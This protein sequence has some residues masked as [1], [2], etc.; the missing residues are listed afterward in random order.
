MKYLLLL[1]AFWINTAAAVCLKYA[2]QEV[3]LSG[4]VFLKTFFGPPNFGENPKT[5]SKLP[6]ALLQLDQPLC[7][8]ATADGFNE[9]ERDQKVITLVPSNKMRLSQFKGKQVTVR[10][11]LFHAMTGYH[12]TPVLIEVNEIL[13]NNP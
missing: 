4:K 1:T 5:D 6:Q 7:T 9:A 8:V 11:T 10:G 12:N 2:P 3:T 13:S